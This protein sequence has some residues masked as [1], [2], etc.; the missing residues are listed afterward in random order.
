MK[1]QLELERL[2]VTRIAERHD[3]QNH[4]GHV[5]TVVDRTC[6]VRP[7]SPAPPP[8]RVVRGGYVPS[9][10][11]TLAGDA[12]LLE[13]YTE[14]SAELLAVHAPPVEAGLMRPKRSSR[15][16]SPKC[17]QASLDADSPHH[18]REPRGRTDQL[19]DWNAPS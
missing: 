12:A 16:V 3:T 11:R 19:S 18:R 6:G 15:R 17:N 8:E 13:C 2:R 1:A 7:R 5:V 9:A 4:R 14:A 10:P